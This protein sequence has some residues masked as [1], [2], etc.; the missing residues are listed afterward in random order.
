MTKTI[1]LFILTI[2]ISFAQS[3]ILTDSI[4]KPGIYL[5]I[6]NIS[7]NQPIDYQSLKTKR[8]SVKYGT[9]GNIKY[10]ESYSPNISSKEAKKFD[11]IIGFCDGKNIYI[12]SSPKNNP[13]RALFHKVEF[14]GHF[15][16]YQGI[17]LVNRQNLM[18]Y[19]TNDNVVD[20][21]KNELIKSLT[22]GKFEKIILSDSLLLNK[23]KKEKKQYL[24]YKE[25][26]TE[27]FKK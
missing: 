23:F 13:K 26:L 12:T 6:N 10:L 11:K 27:Y 15:L 19:V 25:Y 17:E 1:I 3:K 20:L 24:L 9:L 2:N 22:Y 4:L 7:K 14:I 8:D 21:N 18:W 16:Y 5:T